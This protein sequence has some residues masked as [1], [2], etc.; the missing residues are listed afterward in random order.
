MKYWIDVVSKDHVQIGLKNGIIQAC[1]GK[2]Y[3]LAN[4]KTGDRVLFYSPKESLS[5]KT[6][7]QAF[8]AVGTIKNDEIYQFEMAPN[9]IPWRKDIDFEECREISIRPL[10]DELEFITDKIHWG[11]KFRLWMFEI[12]QSDFE[13]IYNLMKQ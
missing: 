9:F 11:Y 12:S 4:V 2:K 6:P 5:W 1:H 8:T 7:L 10:I 3:P 13:R